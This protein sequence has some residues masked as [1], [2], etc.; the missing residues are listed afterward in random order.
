VSIPI[1]F[2]GAAS[3][4][5][6]GP[7]VRMLTNPL[8]V[9]APTRA[10]LAAAYPAKALAAG[11]AGLAT[12]DCEVTGQGALA[13]C[14]VVSEQPKNL[15]FGRA[16]R[17]LASRFRLEAPPDDGTRRKVQVRVPV[18]FSPVLQDGRQITRAEWG[19]LPAAGQ[20]PYPEK[21]RAAGATGAVVLD[22]A[23]A[24]GGAVAD[25][26]VA[27][28]TPQGLG[29]GEAALD[30]APLFRMK[31]WTSDGRPVDGARIRIPINYEEPG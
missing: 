6:G 21:A 22:C 23:V 15:G 30:L 20:V 7:V 5:A 31:A 14:D 10:E 17:L 18:A 2:K 8:W 27:K 26:K 4:V 9:A 16:A 3:M 12:M 1:G 28:E 24:V 13:S 19:R 29:F 25:C 11:K